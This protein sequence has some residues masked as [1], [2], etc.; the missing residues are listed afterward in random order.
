MAR[1]NL[2]RL[3]EQRRDVSM[4]LVFCVCTPMVLLILFSIAS[5]FLDNPLRAS[6]VAHF[7]TICKIVFVLTG[8]P[9]V[10]IGFLLMRQST[11]VA[12]LVH[13]DARPRVRGSIVMA[14]GLALIVVGVINLIYPLPTYV[15]GIMY[16]CSA[17]FLPW[18]LLAAYYFLHRKNNVLNRRHE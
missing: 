6:F 13:I 16:L 17:V 14:N 18:I 5:A 1:A 10:L 7:W 12:T 8:V 15:I 4:L 2:S 11:L 9:L 3:T